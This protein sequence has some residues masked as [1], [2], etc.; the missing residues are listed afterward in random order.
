VASTLLL[1]LRTLVWQNSTVASGGSLRKEMMYTSCL[2]P[3]T[4]PEQPLYLAV[5]AVSGTCAQ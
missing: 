2:E 4:P 3:I 5:V 1:R